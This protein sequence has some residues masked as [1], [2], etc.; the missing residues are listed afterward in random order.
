MSSTKCYP[1]EVVQNRTGSTSLNLYFCIL[2]IISCVLICSLGPCKPMRVGVDLQCGTSMANLHWEERKGVELYMASA[3]CS[4]GITQQCN[5]TNS[6]CQFSNLHC[7]ET[8]TFSVTAYS[9][10]CYS[11][12]S[13]TVEIQTGRAYYHPIINSLGN[14]LINWGK[15]FHFFILFY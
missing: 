10:M 14:W 15:R 5:S 2:L 7:G 4:M 9:N 13:K 3:T 11:E 6:T 12:V 1:R 8:Y